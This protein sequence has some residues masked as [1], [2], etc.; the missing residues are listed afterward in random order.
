MT[1]RLRA[2]KGVGSE[3]VIGAK[4]WKDKSFMWPSVLGWQDI[5]YG[6]G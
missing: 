1:A 2:I 6:L 5:S 3:D 4:K